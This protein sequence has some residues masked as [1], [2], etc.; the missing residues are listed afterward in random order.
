MDNI[1]DIIISENIVN[2]ES[3]Y[4]LISSNIFHEFL[5]N[6]HNNNDNKLSNIFNNLIT[7]DLFQ[8]FC[9]DIS[10]TTSM[11]NTLPIDNNSNTTSMNNT[12]PIDNNMDNIIMELVSNMSIE[13]NT[14]GKDECYICGDILEVEKEHKLDCGHK[15]HLNC[16]KLSFETNCIKLSFGTN[17]EC[18]YCR[19]P[20]YNINV[21]YECN[22]IIKSGK[23][24]GKKC[25][26]NSKFGNYCGKHKSQN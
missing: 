19:K 17:V 7:S 6:I 9:D 2:S 26:S 24:K 8:N 15:F 1:Q 10:N 16:I 5:T 18:P 11:N 3:Y 12:L 13:E 21:L 22:A 23:N 25:I 4:K 14:D 20:C